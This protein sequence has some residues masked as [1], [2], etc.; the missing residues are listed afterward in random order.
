[1]TDGIARIPSYS[2][3]L[4]KTF[5]EVAGSGRCSS[6]HAT[7]KCAGLV[8]AL[9]YLLSGN[10]FTGVLADLTPQEIMAELQEG[11]EIVGCTVDRMFQWARSVMLE[12]QITLDPEQMKAVPTRLVGPNFNLKDY[13]RRVAGWIA[14]RYGCTAALGCG[15]GKTGIST[16]AAIAAHRLGFIKESRCLISAPLNAVGPWQKYLKDL[17]EEFKIVDI[18]SVDSLHYL[19]ALPSNGG[20]IIFDEAH[21][22]KNYGR[23]R[24]DM[25][26]LLRP[27]FEWSVCLTGS[28]LHTGCEAVMS[29]LDLACP[30]LARFTDPMVFGAFFDAI[31]VKKIRGLGK[32]RSLDKPAKTNY[33]KFTNYLL[34]STISLS[35]ES[36]EVK[37]E[38]PLPPQTKYLIDTWEKPQ[39][40]LDLTDEM[41]KQ[42]SAK[43]PQLT[44][45]SF[46]D[47]CP[48]LWGPDVPWQI[49]TAATALASQHVR[50][51][52]FVKAMSAADGKEYKYPDDVQHLAAQI[53]LEWK[54]LKKG[55]A[56]TTEAEMEAYYARKEFVDEQRKL[57][58]MPN[59]SALFWMLRTEGAV[60]RVIVRLVVDKQVIYR[61]VYAPGS[62]EENPA[63]GPKIK[64]IEQWLIDNPDESLFT[65]AAS[66]LS[67][68]LLIKMCEKN[69][70]TYRVIRGGV[71]AKDRS[72]FEDEFQAGIFRVF[73]VQQ[74]AGSEAITCTKATT[75]FLVDHDVSPVP[76]TQY[77]ARTAR[78][79][80][81]QE[82]DHYDLSFV[83]LQTERIHALRRGEEF[84][85]TIRRAIEAAAQGI[86]VQNPV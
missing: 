48:V 73:V 64:L 78:T 69:G 29:I 16:A 76:Y 82:T 71:S 6:A 20:A 86:P 26:H 31:V 7:N 37:A 70:W 41:W 18:I 24:T 56:P 84:D 60:D 62:T 28:F 67:V 65:G 49:F 47:N 8:L 19:L 77:L 59:F 30:G 80:Q 66:S 42:A 74:V 55:V 13:Q 43:D 45:E 46:E 58:G 50:E 15:T 53:H 25:A 51:Q 68:D 40:V 23:D 3:D 22:L 34:R 52:Q 1:M 33:V 11:A 72:T 57:P 44:R 2:F 4:G 54:A 81:L 85:A 10:K 27:R 5:P 12:P 17:R 14:R 21:K 63:P 36:E 32:R 38:N 39:W 61:F 79:G 9:C 83:E 35:F 75:S